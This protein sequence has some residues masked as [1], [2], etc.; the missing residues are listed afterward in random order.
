MGCWRNVKG[1]IISVS[2]ELLDFIHNENIILPNI[3][4]TFSL[5][6]VAKIVQLKKNQIYV[7]VN[8]IFKNGIRRDFKLTSVVVD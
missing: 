8:L 2:I 6:F 5:T 4:S 3:Y 1:E 7:E